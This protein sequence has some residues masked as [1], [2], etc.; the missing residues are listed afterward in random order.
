MDALGPW[1]VQNAESVGVVG[2][3]VLFVVAIACGWVV[4]GPTYVEVKR[5]CEQQELALTAANA[6]LAEHT[7]LAAV[8]GVREEYR[9]RER[10]E[11]QRRLEDCRADLSRCLAGNH[12][13]RRG[14][15]G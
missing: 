12:P 8:Q 6:K 9:Q 1:L 2:L 13:A 4:L 5:D 11:A 7:V 10:D 15:R 3:C 14:D